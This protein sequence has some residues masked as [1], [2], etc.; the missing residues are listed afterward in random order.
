MN[1]H[2]EY[3]Q[4]GACL[5]LR[6]TLLQVWLFIKMYIVAAVAGSQGWSK[7]NRAEHYE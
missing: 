1:N 7:G 2:V 3:R 6:I 5:K 4:L